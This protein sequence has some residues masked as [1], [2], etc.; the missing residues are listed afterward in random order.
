MEEENLKKVIEAVLLVVSEGDLNAFMRFRTAIREELEEI[1]FSNYEIAKLVR[2]LSKAEEFEDLRQSWKIQHQEVIKVVLSAV[3]KDLEAYSRLKDV[4]RHELKARG[5]TE[6][7]LARLAAA[8]SKAREFN[9]LHF[10]HRKAQCEENRPFTVLSPV[11][12]LPLSHRV[13]SRIHHRAK[14]IGE[15]RALD[16]EDILAIRNFGKAGLAEIHAAL[17]WAEPIEQASEDLATPEEKSFFALDQ[18]VS[19]PEGK[20]FISQLLTCFSLGIQENEFSS[21]ALREAASL[22]EA[23]TTAGKAEMWESSLQ[24]TFWDNQKRKA[25]RWLDLITLGLSEHDILRAYKTAEEL[26]AYLKKITL[27]LARFSNSKD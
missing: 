5:V 10:S 7:N 9:D 12:D 13:F 22:L 20:L 15:L 26:S 27:D 8:I 11:K 25:Q 17:E 23:F 2:K 24:E 16:D 18:K 6:S 14:N 21:K 19:T 1:G 4:I 3:S